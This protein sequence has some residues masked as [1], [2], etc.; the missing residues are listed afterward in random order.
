M[1]AA[2]AEAWR[3]IPGW[4]DF[5]ALYDRAVAELAEGGALVEVGAWF[6]RSTAYLA[7]RLKDSGKAAHLYVVDTWRGSPEI[8]LHRQL[9]E[10]LG[11]SAYETFLANMQHADVADVLTPLRLPSHEAALAFAPESLDFV[12]LDGCHLYEEVRRDLES[13]YPKLRAG[14]VLAGHDYTPAW[15]GVVRAVEEFFPA[16]RIVRMGSCFWVRKPRGAA[17]GGE[18]V[19]GNEQCVVLVPVAHH[20]EPECDRA[21]R[22]LEARGYPVRRVW[23]YAAIDQARSQ[24]ATD[25]LAEGFAELLW[26]DADVAFDP[27]DVERLRRH[28]LPVVTALYPKKGQ[29]AFACSL[30]PGT[31]QVVFGAGGGLQEIH[32][33]A[34]GFLLTRREVYAA[35]QERNALPACNTW[36]GR[37]VVPYFLPMVVPHA[38]G[39]WYLGEDFAFFERLR[40]AGY[41]IFADTTVRLWH[42]GR[43]GYSWEE[44][45][46]E[47]PR[48]ATYHLNL[49]G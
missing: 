15:P 38:G 19:I 40:R 25:A 31:T 23:G 32:Y 7:R 8:P 6:G 33:G 3:E 45:G 4:F 35:V 2:R 28:E 27:D 29:R 10:P 14:G 34:T 20:V 24:M 48:Y 22:A 44:A 21:L 26:I 1:S 46:Q 37:P 41:R 49:P 47:L 16:H 13:W 39:H 11:G 30:L 43:Y 9:L 18:T 36:A 17:G 5:E 42:V 12:F